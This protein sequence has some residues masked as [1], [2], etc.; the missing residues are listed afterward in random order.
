MNI[1]T[2]I[3]SL[4]VHSSVASGSIVSACTH[5]IT[6]S[7]SYIVT[8]WPYVLTC[9]EDGA[10]IHSNICL[11]YTVSSHWHRIIVAYVF[12]WYVVTLQIREMLTFSSYCWCSKQKPVLLLMLNTSSCQPFFVTLPCFPSRNIFLFICSHI[13]QHLTLLYRL[14]SQIKLPCMHLQRTVWGVWTIY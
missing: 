10:C 11:L 5:C 14:F 3:T 1:S 13:N 7:L 12:V 4:S 9:H 8:R 2:L 6:L